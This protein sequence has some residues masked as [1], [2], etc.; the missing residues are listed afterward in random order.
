MAKTENNVT[1]NYTMFIHLYNC[2]VLVV[3]YQVKACADNFGTSV[4]AME[5]EVTQKTDA[6]K[7]MLLPSSDDCEKEGV[8][9]LIDGLNSSQEEPVVLLFSVVILEYCL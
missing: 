2:F 5:E 1:S 3:G 8:I 4:R 7:N 9:F 6:Y